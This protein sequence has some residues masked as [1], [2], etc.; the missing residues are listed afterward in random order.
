[1]K[2]Y[3]IERELPGVGR[4]KSNE[5]SGAA[6]R[7]QCRAGRAR[8]AARSG[9]IRTSRD[10]AFCIYL[11]ADE[12]AI[13]E[14]AH[15]RVSGQQDPE[16]GDHRPDDCTERLEGPRSR[17]FFLVTPKRAGARTVKPCPSVLHSASRRRTRAW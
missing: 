1:M 6:A 5:L 3:M 9:C 10:R 11:A 15:Q 4:L 8:R 17:P 7:V 12:R 2:R 13:G 16:S 14:H